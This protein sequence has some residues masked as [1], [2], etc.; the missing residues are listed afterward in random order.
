LEAAVL[1]T[2]ETMQLLADVNMEF[3]NE[4]VAMGLAG[5]QMGGEQ[6]QSHPFAS[7]TW[8][9][10][11]GQVRYSLATAQQAQTG[12]AI[13]DDGTL[14]PHAAV[15]DGRLAPEHGLHQELRWT[16]DLDS[17]GSKMEVA[18]F[19]D[20]WTN[21]IVNGGG[22]VAT[23]D[24]AFGDLLVDPVAGRLRAAAPT[25]GGAGFL[26]DAQRRISP[27][28]MLSVAYALGPALEAAGPP[29]NAVSVS[30]VLASMHP[31]TAQ[32]VTLAANGRVSRTGT[33]WR[34]SYRFQHHNELTPVDPCDTPPE[35]AYLSLF[36]RQRLHRGRVFP[37]GME[38]VVDV[39]NL[40]AQGYYP[41]VTPDGSMLY[42]AQAGRSMQGG[43]AFTF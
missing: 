20:R 38:A 10:A 26:A 5:E 39:R 15:R 32:V 33:Q 34:A 3:G 1:R 23:A 16:R 40:L 8:Q 28:T 7:L 21:S 9:G 36:L 2:A 37:G 17:S 11:R 30:Q 13:A 31:H 4:I 12:S 35:N 14:L 6:I 22:S 27:N 25:Y 42:F 19:N 24:A 29:R 18:V 41:F 43:I